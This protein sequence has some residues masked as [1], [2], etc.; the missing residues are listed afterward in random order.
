MSQ[1]SH[2]NQAEAERTAA[3]ATDLPNVRDR[4]LRSVKVHDDMAAREERV[5]V[6]LKVREAAAAKR[7]TDGIADDADGEDEETD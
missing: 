1:N 2:R 3:A 5:A 6:N 7:K 4:H